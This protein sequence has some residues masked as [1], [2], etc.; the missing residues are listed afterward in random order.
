MNRFEKYNEVVDR[1]LPLQGEGETIATQTVT[2]V[3]KLIY[4]WFNDGDV[5]DNVKS[6]MN[7]WANNLSSYANWL[8]FMG[9]KRTLDKIFDCYNGDEY[10][11]ILAELAE[12]ALDE[13]NLFAMDAIPKV[14]SIYDFDGD[15]KWIDLADQY[16]EEEDW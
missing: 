6:P 5:Y 12:E 15:Y 1:Y 10:E 7:G 11:D 9:Y 13:E 8:A 2:A 14:G 3:T 16:E 4:K